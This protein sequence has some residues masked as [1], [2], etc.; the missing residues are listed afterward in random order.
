MKPPISHLQ[1]KDMQEA[2]KALVRA[3]KRAREI[4]RQTGTAIVVVRD[5]QLVREIPQPKKKIPKSRET[6]QT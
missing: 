3:A 5:G 1:D 6:T 2:P 4:A